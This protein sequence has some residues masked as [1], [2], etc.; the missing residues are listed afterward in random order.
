VNDVFEEGL[1]VNTLTCLAYISFN[2]NTGHMWI[3]F[4]VCFFVIYFP[5]FSEIY[6]SAKLYIL[7]VRRHRL[8]KQEVLLG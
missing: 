4:N 3:S 5:K 2:D 7:K 6:L 8:R 1:K